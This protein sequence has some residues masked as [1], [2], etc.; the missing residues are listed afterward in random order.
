MD[1]KEKARKYENKKSTVAWL[2]IG[3]LIGD[4]MFAAWDVAHGGF[5]CKYAIMITGVVATLTTGIA[6]MKKNPYI[7][8]SKEE[9]KEEVKVKVKK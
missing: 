8:V 2:G 5:D 3:A 1:N 7:K 4:G 6:L 9:T